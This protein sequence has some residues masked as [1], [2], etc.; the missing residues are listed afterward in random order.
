M[1]FGPTKNNFRFRNSL[2]SSTKIM[3]FTSQM[4]NLLHFSKFPQKSSLLNP[5]ISNFLV[6]GLKK[7]IHSKSQGTALIYH[8]KQ[9]TSKR[10]AELRIRIKQIST[11]LTLETH[12]IHQPLQNKFE[13]FQKHLNRPLILEKTSQRMVSGRPNNTA[14]QKFKIKFNPLRKT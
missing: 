3:D 11:N 13:S 2:V 10:L 14:K 6:Y 12:G 9:F 7:K 1:R 4:R 8:L 5:V